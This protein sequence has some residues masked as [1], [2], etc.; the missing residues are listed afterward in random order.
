MTRTSAL[1]LVATTLVALPASAQ[2][3]DLPV[4]L[5]YAASDGCPSAQQFFAR[6]QERAPGVR[7]AEVGERAPI[8]T[9]RV[10]AGEGRATGTLELRSRA[11]EM[12]ERQ[13]ED[14]TC[15]GVV[16]ALALVAVVSLEKPPEP[17]VPAAPRQSRPRTE[18]PPLPSPRR[19]TF[20]WGAGAS[21]IVRSAI[22]PGAALGASAHVD[23]RSTASGAVAPSARLSLRAARSLSD[24]TVGDAA[25]SF[26]WMVG[27]VDVCPLRVTPVAPLSLRPCALGALGALRGKGG[28]VSTPRNQT[29]FWSE[30]GLGLRLEATLASWLVAEAQGELGFPLS[31]HEFVFDEPTREIHTVPSV[32][33]SALIGLTIP[34]K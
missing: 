31:R 30:I 10:D 4:R 5:R 29:G 3:D 17:F 1:S 20:A 32:S 33:G 22:A 13:V 23:T 25:A 27:H 7:S 16:T 26:Q 9:V 2:G 28:G 14:E 8:F 24:A 19:R 12:T 15:D 34:I 6:M 18:R 21:A 11:G